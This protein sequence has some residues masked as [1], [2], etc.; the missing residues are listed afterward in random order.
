MVAL[1]R[2]LVS[3]ENIARDFERC[4]HPA[5]K[6][7]APC[8]ILSYIC[9]ARRTLM[10]QILLVAP[11]KVATPSGSVDVRLFTGDG[12]HRETGHIGLP[13]FTAT[14]SP[15]FYI[16]VRSRSLYLETWK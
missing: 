12:P 3:N 14:T 6:N 13:T 4:V 5:K 7:A 9:K 1:H 10:R 2:A 15:A 8:E 16:H 11:I